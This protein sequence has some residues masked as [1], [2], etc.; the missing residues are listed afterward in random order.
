MKT[1]FS[2]VFIFAFSFYQDID[3]TS[4]KKDPLLIE[5]KKVQKALIDG[6]T[7]RKYELPKNLQ[8]QQKASASSSKEALIKSYRDAGMKN[9]EEYVNLMA[10]Q[11]ALMMD[12]L[13]KHQ[14]L[15]KLDVEKRRQILIEVCKD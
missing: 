1:F 15:K 4:L 3:I 9:A 13:K 2:L 6:I 5:Y 14:E 12:F 8:L 7:S 11:N 10:K